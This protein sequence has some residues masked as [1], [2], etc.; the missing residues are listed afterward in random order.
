M[1]YMKKFW[2]SNG[3]IVIGYLTNSV[4]QVTAATTMGTATNE[5]VRVNQRMFLRD[6]CLVLTLWAISLILGYFLQIFQEQ[7]IQRM[8]ARMRSD[9]A[10]GILGMNAKQFHNYSYGE[11]EALLQSDITFLENNGFKSTYS[12]VRFMGNCGFSLIALCTYSWT[13]IL[14]AGMVSVFMVLLPRVFTR[15]IREGGKLVSG[16]NAQLTRRVEEAIGGYNNIRAFN[17]VNF[18][19]KLIDRGSQSI[20]NASVESAKRQARS[21]VLLSF[22]NIIGQL[23]LIG[24][25]G[26]L[27]LSG[28]LSV[29]SVVSV[30]ELSSKIFDSLGYVNRYRININSTESIINKIESISKQLCPVI[31]PAVAFESIEFTDVSFTYSG[32]ERPVFSHVSFK[33]KKHNVLQILGASGVGKT[34]LLKLITGE[35]QPT[36]GEILLNGVNINRMSDEERSAIIQLVPQEGRIFE[37]SVIENIV[38]DRPTDLNKVSKIIN[39]FN[40]PHGNP[41]NFSGGEK[42]RIKLARALVDPQ[43]LT[44]ID[45]GLAQID[46][47]SAKQLLLTMTSNY[48]ISL[49]IISHRGAELDD[50]THDV[51]NLEHYI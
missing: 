4:L 15:Y 44:L 17:A 26:L 33:L 14:V 25:T 11:Y 50:M 39:I 30:S 29:G 45:E 40:I 36:S 7:T 16:G 10:R 12:M 31:L 48:P 3:I 13:L 8:A 5:L 51:L 41:L 19:R 47:Q 21:G 42:Q 9:V 20:Q 2:S 6:M 18:F 22:T 27:V 1:H 34:T 46:L 38:L 35:L 28:K 43:K 49:I 37:A 23:L 24:A 32:N